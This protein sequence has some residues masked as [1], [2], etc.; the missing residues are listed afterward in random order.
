MCLIALQTHLKLSVITSVP[1]LSSLILIADNNSGTDFQMRR[2]ISIRGC[3]RPSA[4]RSVGRSVRPQLFSNTYQAHLVPCIRPC[5][6]FS[7]LTLP[8][9]FA[10]NFE[11]TL[12]L[13]RNKWLV[14]TTGKIM[15]FFSM[16]KHDFHYYYGLNDEFV[17]FRCDYASLQEVVSVCP[18]VCPMIF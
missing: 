17:N 8:S 18:S 12:I 6:L 10:L 2:R 1:Q 14:R 11:N 7:G 5:F 3:V 15:I 16:D 4:R 9:Y 13:V